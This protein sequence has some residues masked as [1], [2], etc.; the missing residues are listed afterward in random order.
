MYAGIGS[1]ADAIDGPGRD[2]GSMIVAAIIAG[3]VGFWVFL[4]GGLA[5]RYLLRKPKASAVLLVCVPLV[6]LGL[7]AV[8]VLDLSR[9]TT[10]TLAHGLAAAYIGFSV[11]FGHRMIRWTDQRFAHR[12]AGGPPPV[13]N[14]KYGRERVI[15]EWQDFRRAAVAWAISCGLLELA[16][17]II[18]APARTAELSGWISRLTVITAIWGIWTVCTTLW[19]PK[20]KAP[21]TD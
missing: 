7:L 1:H 11:A 2:A 21:A 3:E 19:P 8:T 4:L 5:V 12:F 10:A 14:P 20:P 6:D 9:G 13:K 18:G 16:V 17:L 15:F